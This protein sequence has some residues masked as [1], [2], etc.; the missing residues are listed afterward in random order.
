MFAHNVVKFLCSK[1][2]AHML[3]VI[4]CALFFSHIRTRLVVKSLK[5]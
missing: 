1:V 5:L 3:F 2:L 4:M